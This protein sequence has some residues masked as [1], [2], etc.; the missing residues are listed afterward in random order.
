MSTS[1]TR[2]CYRCG[3]VRPASTLGVFEG[4]DGD[5]CKAIVICDACMDT[6]AFDMWTDRAE[7]SSKNPVVPYAALPAYDHDDPSRDDPARYS[8]IFALMGVAEQD[9]TRWSLLHLDDTALSVRCIACGA[10]RGA[11]LNCPPHAIPDRCVGYM[12]PSASAE[13]S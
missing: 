6:C 13:P 5:A 12:A 4:R 10:Q 9:N 2:D 3:E 11:H 7:W 1:C 8:S